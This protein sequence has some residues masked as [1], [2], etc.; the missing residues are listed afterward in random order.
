LDFHISTGN[1]DYNNA[2]ASSTAMQFLNDPWFR[3]IY[4]SKDFERQLQNRW[5]ELSPK[6][7]KEL[8]PFIDATRARIDASQ[9]A[10]YERWPMQGIYVWPN[11]VVKKTYEEE[12]EYLRNW[13]ISRFSYLDLY[14]K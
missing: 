8:I 9:Q 5:K 12:F 10:N 11:Y 3:Y 4:R 14:Y 7:N 1:C 6:I 13:I 2:S